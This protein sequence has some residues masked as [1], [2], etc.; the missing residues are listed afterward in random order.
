MQMRE[1][2]KH[3]VR[4][5]SEKKNEIEIKYDI[6]KRKCRKI[7]KCLKKFRIYLYEI[8][9]ILKIDV[10]ILIAQLDHFEIDFFAIFL[11]R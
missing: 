10:E 6:I 7:L 11:I 9:F 4:Y 3:F 5:K 1:K 8:H 2:N